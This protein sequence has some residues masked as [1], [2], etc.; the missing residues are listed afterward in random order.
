MALEVIKKSGEKEPFDT[1]KIRRSIQAAADETDLSE[2][3]KKEVVEQV[4]NSAI[5][6]AEGKEEIATSEI[7]EKILDEL[8]KIEP[9]VSAAWRKYDQEKKGES[10][11]EERKEEVE[12][13]LEEG[14]EGESGELE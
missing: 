4:A 5:Q 11:I 10:I 14:E 2:E 13:E 12:G 3:R 1:E 9:S 7:R 6:L 8:D